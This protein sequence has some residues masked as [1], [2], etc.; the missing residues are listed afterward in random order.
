M[1]DEN[2]NVGIIDAA[3][4]EQ[5][6]FGGRPTD[7][8]RRVLIVEE[9]A[10]V[11]RAMQMVLREE[12]YEVCV[13][14]ESGRALRAAQA[15]HPGVIILHYRMTGRTGADVAWEFAAEPEL[16]Q[17]PIILCTGSPQADLGEQFPATG[18]PLVILRKPLKMEQLCEAVRMALLWAPARRMVETNVRQ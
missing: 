16:K 11:A 10:D 1:W 3:E 12:D 13:E 4:G 18:T 14:Q 6:R 17:V 15:F 7:R 2:T 9:N 8:T 5:E